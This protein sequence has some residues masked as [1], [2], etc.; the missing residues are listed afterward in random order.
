MRVSVKGHLNL[1]DYDSKKSLKAIQKSPHF[2][3]F[4]RSWT[5]K[6]VFIHLQNLNI[7]PKNISIELSSKNSF[8][9]LSPALRL[10]C[11]AISFAEIV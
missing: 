11:T 10:T 5:F 3:H 9:F 2:D 6:L 1:D 7:V 4:Q 8:T